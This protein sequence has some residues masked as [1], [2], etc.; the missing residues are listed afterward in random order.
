MIN[1]VFYNNYFFIIFIF[2]YLNDNYI[3]N[4]NNN[5]LNLK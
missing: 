4:K 3:L 1:Y 2:L 5:T